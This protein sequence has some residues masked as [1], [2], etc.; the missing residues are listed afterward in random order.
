[1]GIFKIIGNLLGIGKGYLERRATLKELKQ[2]QEHEIV[3]AETTAMVD[4]IMSNTQSDNEIDLITARDKKYT[5][6]DE[7]IT[8]LFLIPILVASLIPFL[9]AYQNNDWVNLL[10][11]IRQSYES[12][13]RLPSWYKYVLFAI[14][15]DVLGFRSFARK[16]VER[17]YE[18]TD[19]KVKSKKDGDK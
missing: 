15:I 17:W 16:M 11:I 18:R 7:V 3:K 8:Y 5:S 6:K 4:R 13:D 14:I 19:N 1:M 2:L 12:L 10:E 9:V